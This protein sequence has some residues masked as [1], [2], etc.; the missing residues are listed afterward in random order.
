M[1]VE[2]EHTAEIVSPRECHR[3]TASSPCGQIF[4]G[5]L[6]R[7]FSLAVRPS[8]IS[9]PYTAELLR[10]TFHIWDIQ[11]AQRFFPFAW[12]TATLGVNNR[13]NKAWSVWTGFL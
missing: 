3:H 4:M 7:V 8:V 13:V 10:N 12:T 9:I 6:L 11:T 5:E 2:Q 1:K